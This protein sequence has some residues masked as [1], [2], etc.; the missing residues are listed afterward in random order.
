MSPAALGALAG[1]VGGLGLCLVLW[2]LAARR[3]TL[4]ERL[5]PYLRER[6]RTSRLLAERQLHTPFPTLERLLTPWLADASRV[7]ER[8]GSSTVSIRRRLQLAG[9]DLTP[10]QLRME[11]LV[12]AAVAVAVAL[13][14]ALTLGTLRGAPLVPLLAGVLLAGVGGAVARDRVLTT[15]ARRRQERMRAELPDVAELLALAV[16]A[17]QGP[18]GALERVAGTT[19]GELAAEVRRTLV[20]A[21]SGVPLVVAL[22]RMA[23]RTDAP[24]V[25]RFAEGIAVALERGTPLAEVLRAQAQDAREGARQELMETGGKKEIMMMVPVVFLV[26]PV[27]VLFAVF[28]GLAVLE[29]GL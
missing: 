8:L 10:D 20:D 3:I 2:R 21:R 4:T 15:T 9:S 22:E 19:R 23:G 1:L 28:P 14:G 29:V 16:S 24:T 5:T 11:Q 27:T 25:A 18:V 26:L 6:P 7:L 13:L 12:W 17:G